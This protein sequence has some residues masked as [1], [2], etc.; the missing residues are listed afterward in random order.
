M[1]VHSLIRGVRRLFITEMYTLMSMVG[2]DLHDRRGRGKTC[3]VYLQTGED[4]AKFMKQVVQEAKMLYYSPCIFAHKE[5]HERCF[6]RF[7]QEGE[8]IE[9]NG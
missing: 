1:F 7:I 8:Y 9:H 4:K 6:M 3:M 2:S 5:H